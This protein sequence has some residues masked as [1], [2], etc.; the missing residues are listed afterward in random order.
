MINIKR[1]QE[2]SKKIREEYKRYW[3][4]KKEPKIKP[5]DG[6]S[7]PFSHPFGDY[8]E[9]TSFQKLQFRADHLIGKNPNYLIPNYYEDNCIETQKK[10][11]NINKWRFIIENIFK[12]SEENFKMF[13]SF[14]LKYRLAM[15]DCNKYFKGRIKG[16][17]DF[18]GVDGLSPNLKK[19]E[20]KQLFYF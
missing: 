14:Y 10:Y 8:V 11:D 5:M 20:Q 3:E 13:Y 9:T 6:E 7:I 18:Y 15:L 1:M 17:E 19:L 4:N 2:N 16:C 12:I